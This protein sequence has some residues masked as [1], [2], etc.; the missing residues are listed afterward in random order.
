MEAVVIDSK[1]RCPPNQAGVH[2]SGP[3]MLN[4]K[5]HHFILNNL[6]CFSKHQLNN[7]LL[8][9]DHVRSATDMYPY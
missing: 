9:F 7:V 4:L 5:L 2:E 1:V 8:N 3:S 6:T